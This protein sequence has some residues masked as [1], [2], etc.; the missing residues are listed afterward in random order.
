[1]IE[2]QLD[3]QALQARDASALAQLMEVCRS[4]ARI[5]AYKAGAQAFSDD[6]SQDLAMFVLEKFLPRY[7]PD[8]D[9]EPYLIESAR[10][11]GLAYLRRHSKEYLVGAR[12]D[13]ADPVALLVDQNARAEEQMAESEADRLVRQAKKILVERMRTYQERPVND[14]DARQSRGAAPTAAPRPAPAQKAVAPQTEQE[15]RAEEARLA[16]VN[17]PEVQELIRIRRRIG[18]TQEE[19]AKALGLSD[20]SI[21]SIEYG[22]V[23]GE[24]KA[25]VQLARKLE[26]N[27]KTIDADLPGPALIQRWC[28]MLGLPEDDTVE[29]S[30]RIG[31]H[32]STLYRWSVE[33][34]QPHPHRVRR[35][36]AIV[37][38]LAD[39]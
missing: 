2:V 11:M 20:N 13:G 34:T 5:G 33:K 28:K 35:L 26:A 18:L 32:R 27:Y 39:E 14:Q 31:V 22:V 15:T 37:E 25:L 7:D 36:N 4:C 38:V 16:R 1:M 29:L 10:R 17:R 19:M 6:I 9:V 3:V 12:E 21:R 23:A 24:P 8:R 30:R